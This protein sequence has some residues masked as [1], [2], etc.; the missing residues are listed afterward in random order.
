M[1]RPSPPPASTSGVRRRATA[2]ARRE[3]DSAAG[4]PGGAGDEGGPVIHVTLLSASDGMEE[5]AAVSRR[6]AKDAA[7]ASN[8]GAA[9]GHRSTARRAIPIH[10]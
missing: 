8:T 4:E 7:V 10:W 3:S 5:L 1:Q 9:S 2:S 6:L